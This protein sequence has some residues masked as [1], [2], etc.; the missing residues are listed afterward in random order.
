MMEQYIRST[1]VDLGS[2]A[3]QIRPV[4]LPNGTDRP[5][6][7]AKSKSKSKSRWYLLVVVGNSRRASER[8]TV[9]STLDNAQPY[10]R[11]GGHAYY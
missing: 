11:S 2:P 3:R 7:T 5:R 6:G 1:T 10:H 8:A 9:K 4:H